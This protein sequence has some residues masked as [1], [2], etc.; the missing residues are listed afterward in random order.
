SKENSRKSPLG[1]PETNRKSLKRRL[2]SPSPPPQRKRPGGAARTNHLDKR[3][4][5]QKQ[6]AREERN[7]QVSD[8]LCIFCINWQPG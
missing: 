1:E 3:A 8:F 7:A 2:S 4:L 5:Q 6:Q